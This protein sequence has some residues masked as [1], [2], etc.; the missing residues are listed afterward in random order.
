MPRITSLSPTASPTPTLG[1]TADGDGFNLDTDCT[2]CTIE[3]CISYSN[4]GAGILLYG[5]FSDNAWSGNTARYNLTWG[6]GIT[7]SSYGEMTLGGNLANAA[8]YGNTCVSPDG[9]GTFPGPLLLQ[10]TPALTGC[11]IRNNIFYGGG[12][13]DIVY[14]GNA[15]STAEVLLQGNLYYSPNTTTIHWGSDY[16]GLAAF[17][18]GAPGQEQVSGHNVGIQANPQF[19]TPGTTPAVTSPGNLARGSG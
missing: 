4:D 9:S 18:A 12:H 15:G 14:A 5:G 3:Y 19:N 6:N 17:Q 8:V 13:G 11:T 2:S 10:Y 1:T 7:N 16:A